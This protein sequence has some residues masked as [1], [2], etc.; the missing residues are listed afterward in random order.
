MIL[1]AIILASG[2]ATTTIAD[3]GVVSGDEKI[4]FSGGYAPSEWNYDQPSSDQAGIFA[5]SYYMR[6]FNLIEEQPTQEIGWGQWSKPASPPSSKP[7]E[8]CGMHPGGFLCEETPTIT[9]DCFTTFP[10]VEQCTADDE[11]CQCLNNCG[12]TDY[13]T[14]RNCRFWKCNLDDK[15]GVSG[16]IEGGLGYWMYTLATPHVKY[17][18]PGSTSANYE[19]FGG[20]M[21]NDRPQECTKLGG[22]VRVSNRLLI[23]NDM[24]MFEG[25]ADTDGYLGYM[26]S[27]TPLGK[28]KASDA[29]N[30]WTIVLDADN[31]AGPA[32]YVSN[33]FWDM[34][35]NWDPLSSSWSDP[36][37]LIGYIAQG[38]EGGMG[39]FSTVKDGK[40]W[41]RTTAWGFPLDKN[42]TPS[43]PTST[44]FTGHSQYATDWA[45]AAMEPMLSGTGAEADQTVAYIRGKT[46]SERAKPECNLPVSDGFGKFSEERQDP[47]AEWLYPL[48]FATVPTDETQAQQDAD[49]AHCHARFDIDPSKFDC[50]SRPGWCR[51]RRYLSRDSNAASN[52]NGNV[53]A[54]A[55]VP[56]EVKDILDRQAFVETKKNDGRY[57]GPPRPEERPCFE[58]PGPA[59]QD[60]RLYCVRTVEDTWVGY[61]WYRFVDQPELSNVFASLPASER[62]A[63]KCFMQARIERLHAAEAAS[64][65][66]DS[67]F[68]PPQGASNLPAAKVAID[69]NLLL[70]PPAG[71]EI[72][73]VPIPVYNRLR[74][75]PAECEVTVGNVQDEPSPLA[76]N[77]FGGAQT[78]NDEREV[79]RCWMHMQMLWLGWSE[80]RNGDFFARL[81][82]AFI[83]ITGLAGAITGHHC[84]VTGISRLARAFTGISRLASA[85]TGLHYAVTGISRLAR[86]FTGISRLASAITGLHYAFTSGH[87]AFT[88]ITRFPIAHSSL[89]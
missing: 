44:L 43:S 26:L 37:S 6:V 77:H 18:L 83:G 73:Y 25:G 64:T 17:M 89:E 32:M 65:W 85:I 49:A 74:T 69:A 29:A 27:R 53:H 45:V 28:R 34:R 48:G 80:L 63:A 68:E 79:E 23:P 54:D 71:M 84:A 52:T 19:V 59:P 1:L 5:W 56:Q 76:S 10:G 11:A 15:G 4:N 36:R 2:L 87:D 46:L 41:R 42:S 82:N 13:L 81:D 38:F 7:L 51:G 12:A 86:A 30:Y 3:E 8:V 14:R 60:S 20:T 66:T 22:A 39:S 67:W 72:G 24:I 62:D 55:D 88:G 31:Y 21:L 50:T 16:S 9:P 57:L 78:V 33:W 70:T 61:K 47:E 35:T 58:C 75:K 40:V